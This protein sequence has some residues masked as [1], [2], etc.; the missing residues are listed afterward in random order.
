VLSSCLGQQAT[1]RNTFPQ[2]ERVPTRY[3]DSPPLAER[4]V[5][6]I[7]SSVLTLGKECLEY[8][9][10]HPSA[11]KKRRHPP[12]DPSGYGRGRSSLNHHDLAPPHMDPLTTLATLRWAEPYKA[13]MDLLP[14]GFLHRDP[15]FPGDD[16]SPRRRSDSRRQ[17]SVMGHPVRV[18]GGTERGQP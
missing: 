17:G 10:G 3:S 9:R 5:G 16:S 4:Q 11:P 18:G 2:G 8:S 6:I 14:L 7:F 1:W 15:V 12:V 13:A